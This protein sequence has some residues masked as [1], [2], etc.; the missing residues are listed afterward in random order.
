MIWNRYICIYDKQHID[1]L[2]VNRD[3][4]HVINADHHIIFAVKPLFF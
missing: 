1:N 2:N 3:Y 4:I